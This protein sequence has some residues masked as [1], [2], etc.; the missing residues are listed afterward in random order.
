LRYDY[1]GPFKTLKL[2]FNEE[3]RSWQKQS[4]K[5]IV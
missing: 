4:V 1:S 2:F 5:I 3:M